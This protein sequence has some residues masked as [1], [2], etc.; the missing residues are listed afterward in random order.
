MSFLGELSHGGLPM[1]AAMGSQLLAT[2][3]RWHMGTD[4]DAARRW[5]GERKR[6]MEARCTVRANLEAPGHVRAIHAAAVE[7]GARVL[8]TNTFQLNPVALSR[9]GLQ[10][11]LE[12]IAGRAIQLARS[13][14]PRAWVLGDVGPIYSP[15]RNEE[16]PD[17]DALAR[18]LT[19]LE[20]VDG[21]LFETCSSPAALSA[22]EF[23]QYRVAAVEGLP[24]L[25]S[26]TYHRD[27][28]GQLVTFSGHRP[29]TFAR[30]AARHGVA[31][32]GVN[33]GRDIDI[34]DVCEILRRYREYTD[35]PLFARPNAG[36]PDA[37]GRY[38]RSPEEMAAGVPAMIAAGASMIGGCC[39][40][41]A[42]YIAV[43]SAVLPRSTQ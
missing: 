43:F 9:D 14:G 34:T 40:T 13:A 8:L 32:L 25:L 22:V 15:G 28:H 3:S 11:Q 42:A 37:E 7:A 21:I 10:E 1:D 5:V 20:G 30:H 6:I 2:G 38:P 17:R 39:G 41:T 36:T 33:C 29:E 12:A 31:A 18:V 35:V 4:L 16:F 19:A 23:A 27:T 24:L 26:L